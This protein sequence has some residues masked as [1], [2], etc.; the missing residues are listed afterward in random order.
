[1]AVGI[2][3]DVFN[4]LKKTWLP[5]RVIELERRAIDLLFVTVALDGYESKFNENI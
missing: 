2:K 4:L 1:M 5:G 3:L